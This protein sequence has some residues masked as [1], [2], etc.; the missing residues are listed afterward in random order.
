MR[1]KEKEGK[2]GWRGI[3]G[4]REWEGKEIG[5]QKNGGND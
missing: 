5:E 1:M 3:Q 2:R 4:E